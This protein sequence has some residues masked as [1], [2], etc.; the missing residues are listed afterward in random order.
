VELISEQ[1]SDDVVVVSQRAMVARAFS[2]GFA[3]SMQVEDPDEI[4]D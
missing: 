4:H 2:H 3:G 1:G